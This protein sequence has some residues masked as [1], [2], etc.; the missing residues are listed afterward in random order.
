[1]FRRCF[2]QSDVNISAF[3]CPPVVY[4]RQVPLSTGTELYCIERSRNTLFLISAINN[5]DMITCLSFF[6][7]ARQARKFA[8]MTLS[9]DSMPKLEVGIVLSKPAAECSRPV[10]ISDHGTE[11]IKSQHQ[12]AV[13]ECSWSMRGIMKGKFALLD[14]FQ[15]ALRYAVT[16]VLLDRLA[17]ESGH[18]SQSSIC[19]H[20]THAL[21]KTLWTRK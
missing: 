3:P 11:E 6:L 19:V 8:L 5:R 4:I 7:G 18:F 17:C 15:F 21:Q 14:A 10:E 20:D 2:S 9:S 13:R 16:E 1:M 12:V